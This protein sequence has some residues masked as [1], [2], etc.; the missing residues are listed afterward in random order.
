MQTNATSSPCVGYPTLSINARPRARAHTHLSKQ[1][2]LELAALGDRS[3]HSESWKGR[4]G[5]GAKSFLTELLILHQFESRSFKAENHSKANT[6]SRSESV[7]LVPWAVTNPSRWWKAEA[8]G[9]KETR[10]LY[11]WTVCP[12]THARS[13]NHFRT[14]WTKNIFIETKAV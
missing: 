11:R 2:K 14:K 4:N 10:E 3:W 6:S 9:L 5:P 8:S 7:A 12:L 1:H 13:M